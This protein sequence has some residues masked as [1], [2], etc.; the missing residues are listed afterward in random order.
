V[1]ADYSSAVR[2]DPGFG[3]GYYNRG[4][5]YCKMRQFK[6]AEEDFSTAIGCIG[7]FAEAYF[8][9]GL[10]RILLND[11]LPGC[12]DLSRAGE[13]GISDAYRVIKRYCFR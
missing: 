4:I 2:L 13:L 3:F 5:V 11:N 1:I 8:N 12:E 7:N 9:R 6:K 10:V